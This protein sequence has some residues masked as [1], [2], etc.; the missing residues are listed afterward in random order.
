MARITRLH[1]GQT[2]ASRPHPRPPCVRRDA[3]AVPWALGAVPLCSGRD[4]RARSPTYPKAWFLSR[5]KQQRPEAC[6]EPAPWKPTDA[7]F[8]LI[9]EMGQ[10]VAVQHAANETSVAVMVAANPC[11]VFIVLA[12]GGEHRTKDQQPTDQRSSPARNDGGA[13]DHECKLGWAPGNELG[14]AKPTCISKASKVISSSMKLPAVLLEACV[15][16]GKVK[17]AYKVPSGLSHPTIQPLKLSASQLHLTRPRGAAT[18]RGG[19]FERPCLKRRSRYP[20]R[21]PQDPPGHQGQRDLHCTRYERE[22]TSAFERY[23]LPRAR[24][25]VLALVGRHRR[26]ETCFLFVAALAEITD[27]SRNMPRTYASVVLHWRGRF[28]FGLPLELKVPVSTCPI[29]N[30]ASNGIDNSKQTHSHQV[31]AATPSDSFPALSLFSSARFL[32]L[33]SRVSR[34][35][36]SVPP[37]PPPPPPPP[38]LQQKTHWGEQTNRYLSSQLLP[39][40]R[41]GHGLLSYLYGYPSTKLTPPPR[42]SD[43]HS[44]PPFPR[45]PSVLDHSSRH[46]TDSDSDS[47]ARARHLNAPTATTLE[48]PGGLR[49]RMHKG[50]THTHARARITPNTSFSRNHGSTGTGHC[51]LPVRSA[52]RYL[53]P[54]HWDIC[55]PRHRALSFGTPAHSRSP[56]PAPKLAFGGNKRSPQD[57]SAHP[58]PRAAL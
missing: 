3:S 27:C 2:P 8:D 32:L 7:H 37:L 48:V 54:L 57:R 43:V 14:Q 31:R 50:T 58:L 44:P 17:C 29:C 56:L 25:I 9:L 40:R 42:P 46:Q 4:A 10:G 28:W 15:P 30:M 55:I 23:L 47:R 35:L 16:S 26:R 21:C 34:A 38:S 6:A 12:L 53:A 52:Q 22:N 19:C 33:R 18:P 36:F 20:G 13:W 1:E 39:T 24:Y 11:N 5:R 45:F 51:L 49:R 41:Y